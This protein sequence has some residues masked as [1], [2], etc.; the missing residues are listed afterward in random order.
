MIGNTTL[1]VGMTRGMND[2]ACNVACFWLPLCA[3][4]LSSIGSD[5]RLE[6]VTAISKTTS[7]S[8]DASTNAF[9]DR[10][11]EDDKND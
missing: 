4:I 2:F 11:R 6:V 5:I 8:Q 9:Q 3:Y 10:R 1:A 7:A